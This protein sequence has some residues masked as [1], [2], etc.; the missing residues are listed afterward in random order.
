MKFYLHAIKRVPG[1]HGI[2]LNATRSHGFSL[3]ETAIALAVLGLV[4]L[5]V[6]GFFSTATKVRVAANDRDLLS[7]SQVAVVSFAYAN[8]RLPC[9]ALNQSGVEAPGCPPALQ[10]GF[11]PWRTLG[12]PDATAG[13]IR[14][15]VRRHSVPAPVDPKQNLDLSVKLDRF[16]PLVPSQVIAQNISLV[17]INTLLGVANQIDFCSALSRINDVPSTGLLQTA[18]PDLA[19]VQPVAFALALPGLNDADG[20]GNK[21]DGF[22]AGTTPVFNAPA[23]PQSLNYDDQVLAM[24]APT[25]FAA[26]S[27]GLGFSAAGHSHFNALN[28]AQIMAKSFDD[29]RYQ[30][31]LQSLMAAAGVASGAATIANSSAGLASSVATSA[32]A[33][34][35]T[36]LAYGTVS[37]ILAPAALAAAANTAA[38]ITAGLTTAAAVAA[39]AAAAALV[40]DFSIKLVPDSI[41]LADTIRAHALAADAAGF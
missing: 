16:A 1:T 3:V 7:R 5:L 17:S 12:L 14:Y 28:S 2:G 13:E 40:V 22:Q 34:A 19:N 6:V 4:A 37:G 11:L 23:T 25:L 35:L 10:V 31:I 32:A 21:F 29:Y 30:L 27:C 41:T 24:S 9:P 18:N 39:A 15:G 38:V 36:L 20:D 8:N 26:L 33:I